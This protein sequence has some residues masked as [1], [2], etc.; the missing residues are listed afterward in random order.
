M[1]SNAPSSS[2]PRRSS[3]PFSAPRKST[4]YCGGGAPA[5]PVWPV[6]LLSQ[7]SHTPHLFFQETLDLGAL[8]LPTSVWAWQA[9]PLHS[10]HWHTPA[11]RPNALLWAQK[12]QLRPYTG[13][14][15]SVPLD[16]L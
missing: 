3:D 10:G 7:V 6:P 13:S 5:S 2:V 8:A 9:A 12:G 15:P 14:S 4:G 11:P 1:P 16:S